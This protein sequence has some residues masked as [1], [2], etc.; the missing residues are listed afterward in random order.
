MRNNAFPEY[1]AKQQRFPI[2]VVVLKNTF[3]FGL[4]LSF[5]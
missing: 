1:K 4:L 2:M 3:G 5:E